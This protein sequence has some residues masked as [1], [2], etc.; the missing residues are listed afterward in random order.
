MSE[1]SRV[2]KLLVLNT[3]KLLYKGM[4]YQKTSNLFN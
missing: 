1:F 4:Q 3:F 2:K